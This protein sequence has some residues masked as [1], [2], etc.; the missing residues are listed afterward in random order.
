MHLPWF[1]FTFS[2]TQCLLLFS[3]VFLLFVFVLSCNL[4]GTI[5]MEGHGG[6][7]VVGGILRRPSTRPSCKSPAKG[8]TTWLLS[9]PPPCPPTLSKPWRSS[10]KL[11]QQL[12]PSRGFAKLYLKVISKCFPVLAISNILGS[13]SPPRGASVSICKMPLSPDLLHRLPFLLLPSLIFHEEPW[14]PFG[15]SA[16]GILRP[17]HFRKMTS[18]SQTLSTFRDR[19]KCRRGISH[20]LRQ[21]KEMSSV[22]FASLTA[23]IQALKGDG[24]RR[25]ESSSQEIH[26]TLPV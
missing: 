3:F 10:P 23:A 17:E 11:G 4:W 18:E 26:V 21:I 12:P 6:G 1:K 20:L 15:R 19:V 7:G 14:N 25:E 24:R 22:F 9:G 5:K 2:Q 8:N 13:P 16:N